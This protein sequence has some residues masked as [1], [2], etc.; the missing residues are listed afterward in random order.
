MRYYRFSFWKLLS[1]HPFSLLYTIIG[2]VLSIYSYTFSASSSRMFTQSM[3]LLQGRMHFRWSALCNRKRRKPRHTTRRILSEKQ[4]QKCSITWV[5]DFNITFE[6]CHINL[7]LIVRHS[8]V[9]SRL[10]KFSQNLLCF[11]FDVD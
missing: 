10:F 2:I 4:K 9:C 5:D 6:F 11:F 7:L 1:V 8:R 3:V